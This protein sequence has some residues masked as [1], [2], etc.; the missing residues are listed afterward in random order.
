MAAVQQLLGSALI[1]G[2]D[3][4]PPP[5]RDALRQSFGLIDGPAPDPFLVGMAVLGVIADLAHEQPLIF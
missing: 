1:E 4:S 2:A 5:Q 3:P